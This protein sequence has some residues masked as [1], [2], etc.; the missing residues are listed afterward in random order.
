MILELL[1][2]A[3]KGAVLVT[4]L[5]VV[6]M[7]MIESF[8]ISTGGK[9]FGGLR[10]SRVGQVLLSAFLGS[11][12]GCMGGFASV[13]LYTHGM[14]SFGALVAMMIASSGDE[15]FV[16]LAMFPEKAW[17]IFLVLF[18]VAVLSGLLVDALRIRS[19]RQLD[20]AT[21]AE[22]LEIHSEDEH[23]YEHK[24][25]K[26]ASDGTSEAG[27]K[28]A[29]HF[30]WK[31]LVMFIG[32]AAFIGALG[33]GL[34]E[35]EHEHEHEI[36]EPADIVIFDGGTSVSAPQHKRADALVESTGL[37]DFTETVEHDHGSEHVKH[38]SHSAG[39]DGGINLLSED[40]MNILFAIL[41]IV[42]L[43][44]IVWGSDH[45]V[46]EHLWHHV[47]C[48]HLPRIFAWTFGVLIVLG[49][50]TQVFDASGWISNNTLLMI[51]LATAIGII[52]ESG[53]HLI[54]VTL[55]ASGVVPLPVLLASCISQDGHASLPLLAESKK[56]FLKAKAINCLVALAVGLA[57]WALL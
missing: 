44:V 28:P 29:R 54:F 20:A 31:R 41:S 14:I 23:R 2:D 17:W 40:W 18:V 37:V 39:H 55:F 36:A 6:M 15:A 9:A 4:G 43:C 12:P 51:L 48:K 16:M 25:G 8:N 24:H 7:M 19:G 22:G 10:R 53:P 46:D 34:L 56:D 45:F 38:H 11:I 27:G 32:V 47:I 30:S 3:L 35:H 1:F 26:E 5:V 13:S 50:L 42:V 57:T 52:P 49:L 21:C 33:F